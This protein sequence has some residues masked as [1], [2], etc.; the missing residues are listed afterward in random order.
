L[1]LLLSEGHDR[2][3]HYPLGML[4]DEAN[5]VVERN[6]ARIV[7]EARLLRTA[8]ASLLIKQ[9]RGHFEKMTKSLNVEVAPHKGLFGEE[10]SISMDSELWGE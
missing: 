3:G 1:N 10:G 5:L 4:Y 8:V 6:N 2:P 9:S 7:T